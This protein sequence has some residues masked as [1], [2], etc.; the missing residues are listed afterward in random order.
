MKNEHTCSRPGIA[1]AYPT[2]RRDKSQRLYSI[3]KTTN[4][5]VIMQW[6]AH[7]YEHKIYP[8]LFLKLIHKQDVN[9]A[10]S[11]RYRV[12]GFL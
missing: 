7:T 5:L 1:G 9:H 10:L 11:Y 4:T 12:E 3:D 2:S 6:R 8:M